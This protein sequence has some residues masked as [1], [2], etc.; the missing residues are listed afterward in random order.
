MYSMTDKTRKGLSRGGSGECGGVRC[1]GSRD[2][3]MPRYEDMKKC[4]KILKI[5]E[6][7]SRLESHMEIDMVTKSS[8]FLYQNSV[9]SQNEMAAP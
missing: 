1:L 7:A 3:H 2:S 4:G 9:T 5:Q 6:R 8:C